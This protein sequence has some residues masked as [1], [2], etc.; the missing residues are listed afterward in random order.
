VTIEDLLDFLRECVDDGDAT[1][2]GHVVALIRTPEQPG[3]TNVIWEQRPVI[4]VEYDEPDCDLMMGEGAR[5]GGMTID[6]LATRLRALPAPA[7]SVVYIRGDCQKASDG[8]AWRHDIPVVQTARSREKN[9][10][11]LI[12]EHEGIDYKIPGGLKSGA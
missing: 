12:R 5:D 1:P 9:L 10:A 4:D 8:S 3:R 6:R 11:G 2:D 7:E